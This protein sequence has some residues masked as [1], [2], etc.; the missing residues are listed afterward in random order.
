[1]RSRGA[2]TGPLGGVDLLLHR[3]PV[4]AAG[5]V[6]RNG[7]GAARGGRAVEQGESDGL[8]GRGGPGEAHAR[9]RGGACEET[10]GGA[11]GEAGC[12]GGEA[13][14]GGGVGGVESSGE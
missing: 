4:V 9:G 8:G 3:A 12:G 6:R 7:D 14:G 11:G 13:G 1:M 2:H 10:P 5:A